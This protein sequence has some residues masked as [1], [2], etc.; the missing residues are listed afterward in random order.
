MIGDT[1][2]KWGMAIANLSYCSTWYRTLFSDA[3]A[4]TGQICNQLAGSRLS[5]HGPSDVDALQP[6]SGNNATNELE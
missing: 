5:R 4:R 1:V 2:G 6:A 3:V